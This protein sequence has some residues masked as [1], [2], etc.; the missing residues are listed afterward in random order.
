MKNTRSHSCIG[1]TARCIIVPLAM[2]L[3]SCGE[4]TKVSLD[5]VLDQLKAE[6]A[7]L[8][9][10]LEN[11]ARIDVLRV[12][13]ARAGDETE[14]KGVIAQLY[15][16]DPQRQQNATSMAKDIGGRDMIRGLAGTLGDTNGWRFSEIKVSP[17]GELPQGV[18]MYVPPS[19]LAIMMLSQMVETPPVMVKGTAWMRYTDDDV[20][21]WKKW[22]EENKT[23]YEDEGK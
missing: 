1:K 13:A 19:L 9:T 4:E 16:T 20:E 11:P 6:R 17:T 12:R 18:I 14:R 21:I 5:S 15:D 10:E 23:K 2:A 3:V 8:N 22:W 7:R